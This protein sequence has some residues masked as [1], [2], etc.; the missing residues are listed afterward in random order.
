MKNVATT[1]VLLALAF[2]M[3]GCPSVSKAEAKLEDAVEST[4]DTVV[5]NPVTDTVVDAGKA[6]EGAVETTV[7]KSVEVVTGGDHK[8]KQ[9]AFLTTGKSGRLRAATDALGAFLGTKV[10]VATKA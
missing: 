7:D 8:K 10:E 1:A 5:H 9:S 2:L 6:V 3:Q 4:V